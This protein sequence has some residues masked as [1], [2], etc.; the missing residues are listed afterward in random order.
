VILHE[1]AIEELAGC[2][3]ARIVRYEDL[4]SSAEK[5]AK[6]LFAF[7]QLQWCEATARFI[8][9]SQNSRLPSRYFGVFRPPAFKSKTDRWKEVLTP[10]E[11]RR[12]MEIVGDSA[13]GRLYV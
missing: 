11:A 7:A 13:P 6:D 10:S 12:V 9:R 8:Y 4:A 3:N 1:K 2:P 5:T